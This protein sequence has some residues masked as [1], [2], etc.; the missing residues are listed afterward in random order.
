MRRWLLIVLIFFAW[1]WEILPAFAEP[2]TCAQ[3]GT[4]PYLTCTG[5]LAASLEP[6]EHTIITTYTDAAGKIKIVTTKI[7]TIT[8]STLDNIVTTK[9]LPLQA[10]AISQTVDGL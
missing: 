9:G 7:H 4:E 1:S 10:T 3:V 5:T 2:I 6:G 8:I